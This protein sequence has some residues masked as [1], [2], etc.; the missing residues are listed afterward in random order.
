MSEYDYYDPY[1]QPNPH[2]NSPP[3]TGNDFSSRNYATF[4]SGKNYH[5]FYQHSDNSSDEEDSPKKTTLSKANMFVPAITI[6]KTNQ[7]GTDSVPTNNLPQICYTLHDFIGY[8]CSNSSQQSSLQNPRQSPTSTNSPLNGNLNFSDLEYLLTSAPLDRTPRSPSHYRNKLRMY[9]LKK[10]E[11][12]GYMGVDDDDYNDQ[13]G[14]SVEE[15]DLIMGYDCDDFNRR[16][17]INQN[18]SSEDEW[19]EGDNDGDQNQTRTLGQIKG[20]YTKSLPHYKTKKGIRAGRYHRIIPV[21]INQFG[22]NNTKRIDYL[23]EG[24]LEGI[25][26]YKIAEKEAEKKL[27]K[28]R[29]GLL[30]SLT[31]NDEDDGDQ[32]QLTGNCDDYGIENPGRIIDGFDY[33]DI[34]Y[35]QTKIKN[36]SNNFHQNDKIVMRNAPLKRQ[37]FLKNYSYYPSTEEY[38]LV[39]AKVNS[40]HLIGLNSQLKISP[41]IFLFQQKQFPP[42]LSQHPLQYSSNRSVLCRN[43]NDMLIY[44][45]TVFDHQSHELG[46]EKDQFNCGIVQ[47]SGNNSKS[48]DSH[49]LKIL[50]HMDS[51]EHL[52]Y[53]VLCNIFLQTDEG[54]GESNDKVDG[55]NC[56]DLEQFSKQVRKNV[57]FFTTFILSMLPCCTP[58]TRYDVKQYIMTQLYRYDVVNVDIL[59]IDIIIEE[60]LNQIDSPKAQCSNIKDQGKKH[61][62]N[63]ETH[64]PFTFWSDKIQIDNNNYNFDGNN[65]TQ[66]SPSCFQ[67]Y[68][69]QPLYPPTMKGSSDGEMET[70]EYFEIMKFIQDNLE[71]KDDFA[72]QV[73]RE[74]NQEERTQTQIDFEAASKLIDQSTKGFFTSITQPITDFYDVAWLSAQWNSVYSDLLE[75]V[76]D[77]E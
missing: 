37:A 42:K 3:Q 58:F 28:K 8:G 73:K 14:F 2:G 32:I 11:G 63:F 19:S 30:A 71:I 10:K 35:Q 26:N 44:Q 65:N 27:E 67:I 36:H 54:S 4:T 69:P 62:D 29:I 55:H 66:N 43:Y 24:I 53:D 50:S 47:N 60:V 39:S 13:N 57:H 64:N 20:K 6:N 51:I 77:E 31:M 68:F 52:P 46:V 18:G 22:V 70:G 25:K 33:G 17:E 45:K 7:R 21:R 61:D 9:R 75:A 40:G 1:D 16:V 72:E 48:V 23:N 74:Q 34:Q 41:L 56:K 38:F 5:N 15:I 12:M 49:P 76:R 59:A